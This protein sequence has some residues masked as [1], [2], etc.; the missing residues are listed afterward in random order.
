VLEQR[1]SPARLERSLAQLGVDAELATE[2]AGR[3]PAVL[4]WARPPGGVLVVGI[5]ETGRPNRVFPARRVGDEGFCFHRTTHE[6][7][8]ALRALA[9]S[10]ASAVGARADVSIQN[11]AP[12]LFNDPGLAATVERTAREVLGDAGVEELAEPS[13]GGEDFSVYGKHAPAMLVR[14]GTAREGD[15]VPLHSN[16]F[17]VDDRAIVPTVVLMASALVELVRDGLGPGETH[18][19]TALDGVLVVR[20]VAASSEHAR[21]LLI[22]AWKLVRPSGSTMATSPS[23]S[24]L[25]A[26][27]PKRRANFSARF[28]FCV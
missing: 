4:A 1:L 24:A 12:P 16:V 14:V 22:A 21:S 19:T 10:A 11:G 8:A 28:S 27:M 26:P 7:D 9:A 17:D 5:R 25:V 15:Y 20:L 2:L 18:A 13:M 23:S 6:L 3:V